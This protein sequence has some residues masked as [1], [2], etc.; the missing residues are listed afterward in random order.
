MK[1]LNEKLAFTRKNDYK[2]FNIKAFWGNGADARIE[3]IRDGNLYKEFLYPAYKIFNISAH[4]ED[5]VDGI[6]NGNDSGF[7][8]AG[9]TGLG[10]SVM[11]TDIKLKHNNNK[12]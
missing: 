6:L 5:I 3:L 12:S 9:S 2:G 11:P 1:L 4:F 8:V 10:G 7:R